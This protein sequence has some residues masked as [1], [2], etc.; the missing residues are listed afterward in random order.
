MKKTLK[1]I[2]VASLVAFLS[3]TLV[4]CGSGNETAATSESEVAVESTVEMGE[5]V[6]EETH[7][8]VKMVLL[9]LNCLARITALVI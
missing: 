9:L 5:E 3:V 2:S 6:S 8:V 4:A 1:K 7:E